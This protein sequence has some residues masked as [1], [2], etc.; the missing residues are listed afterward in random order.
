MKII[1]VF[2]LGVLA[3]CS[4]YQT[5]EELEEEALVTGDWSAVEERERILAKRAIRHGLV[6]P[7]GSMSY[8]ESWAG[9]KEKC[10]C[11]PDDAGEVLLVR[12]R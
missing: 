10:A 7:A 4:S 8:C 6:C 5:L 3:G 11:I 1:G 9:L 12:S 2:I